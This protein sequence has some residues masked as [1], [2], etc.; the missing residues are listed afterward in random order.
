MNDLDRRIQ[1]ALRSS[2]EGSA[3]ADEPAFTAELVATFRQR[4]R[5]LHGYV[6]SVT[7]AC[8]ATGIWAGYRLLTTDSAQERIAF[9]CVCILG[10]MFTGFLKLYVL[11]SMLN[12]RVLR[13]LKR[14]ELLLLQRQQ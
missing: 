1:E 2:R 13:E 8:F 7:V 3:L 11:F 4:N 12:N 6:L 14:F 5:W 9:G 10:L